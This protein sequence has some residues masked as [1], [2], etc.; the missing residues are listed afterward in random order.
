MVSNPSIFVPAMTN[1]SHIYP[2]KQGRRQDRSTVRLDCLVEV[3][4][5]GSCRMC[6][7]T[8]AMRLSRC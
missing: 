1:W 8:K 4:N 5:K 3:K 2:Y 6:C 7:V